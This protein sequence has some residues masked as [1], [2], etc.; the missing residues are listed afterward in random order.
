[1]KGP[2]R[3][4]FVFLVTG[5]ILSLLVT[6]TLCDCAPPCCDHPCSSNFP[7]ADRCESVAV[8]GCGHIPERSAP[9]S[10]PTGLMIT[11]FVH[12]FRGTTTLGM[13]I[14]WHLPENVTGLRGFYVHVIKTSYVVGAQY[15]KQ[16][17]FTPLSEA[18]INP[19]E[20]TFS[21]DCWKDIDVDGTY[22]VTVTSLDSGKSITRSHHAK[23]CNEVPEVGGCLNCSGENCKPLPSPEDWHPAHPTASVAFEDQV[24]IIR[25]FFHIYPGN[26][27]LI[28]RVNLYSYELGIVPDNF[29]HFVNS[30]GHS[31]LMMHE[32]RD[33]EPGR[34]KVKVKIFPGDTWQ[35]SSNDVNI[36]ALSPVVTTPMSMTT[37]KEERSNSG[38]I[39]KDIPTTIGVFLSVLFAI[40]LLV[41]LVVWGVRKKRRGT[42]LSA[43][44][45]DFTGGV[46]PHFDDRSNLPNNML[47]EEDKVV[48]DGQHKVNGYEWT[49]GSVGDLC[50]SADYDSQF[51][52]RYI[53]P[54]PRVHKLDNIDDFDPSELV[55]IANMSGETV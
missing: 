17:N 43:S 44:T 12:P 37:P 30:S 41:G 27:W 46:T 1:M 35:V 48:K 25:V 18:P 23:S 38:P 7:G 11:D 49:E 3:A 33:V 47:H 13:N 40:L 24:W 32:F 55:S 28:Y 19:S 26:L 9:P 42:G 14:T 22:D 54:K 31:G 5:L 8:G 4:C 39:I 51:D 16:V 50:C 36:T 15:C 29:S 21:I 34:Y 45:G 2:G 10:A 53:D 52:D 20:V 6:S